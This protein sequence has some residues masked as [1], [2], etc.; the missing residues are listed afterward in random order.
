MNIQKLREQLLNNWKGSPDD[1]FNA[2]SSI[3]DH[4][5]NE[6]FRNMRHMPFSSFSRIVNNNKINNKTLLNIVLY[7]IN[8]AE[9]LDLRY[10]FID[11]N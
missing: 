4:I 6:P 8:I 5:L 1:V 11:E 3:I 2:Y 9:L 7:I 10:E